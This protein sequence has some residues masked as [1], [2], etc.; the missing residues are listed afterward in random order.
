MAA[1]KLKTLNQNWLPYGESS[2]S[3]KNNLVNLKLGVINK[4]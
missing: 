2:K 4:I 3:Y 1:E